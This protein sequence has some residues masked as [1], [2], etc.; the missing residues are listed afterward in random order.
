M[1][2]FQGKCIPAAV[3][4]ATCFC[5]CLFARPVPLHEG[6]ISLLPSSFSSPTAN[7]ILHAPSYLLQP[8]SEA[9]SAQVRSQ[10]CMLFHAATC[11]SHEMTTGPPSR[12]H[13]LNPPLISARPSTRLQ[14]GSSSTLNVTS[15]LGSCFLLLEFSDSGIS[16][17]PGA[18]CLPQTGANCLVAW[19]SYCVD[20]INDRL[21]TRS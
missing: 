16:T 10:A 9:W 18:Q 3:G 19:I 17:L 14:L 5:L 15:T 8:P 2:Y 12:E 11:A 13:P 1:V 20:K 4:V 6:S 21:K 7:L